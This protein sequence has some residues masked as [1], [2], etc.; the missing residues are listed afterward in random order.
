M[1]PVTPSSSESSSS[2][3]ATKRYSSRHSTRRDRHSHDAH[4]TTP[5][6]SDFSDYEPLRRG[7]TGRGCMGLTLTY[8]HRQMVFWF[9]LSG[10]VAALAS[11]EWFVDHSR[12]EIPLRPCII[13]DSTTLRSDGPPPLSQLLTQSG[14][15]GRTWYRSRHWRRRRHPSPAACFSSLAGTPYASVFTQAYIS[16]ARCPIL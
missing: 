6:S 1:R 5:N 11:S 3:T 12:P 13:Y 10:A 14:R 4:P 2:E 16:Q 8:L 15:A 7:C 9:A